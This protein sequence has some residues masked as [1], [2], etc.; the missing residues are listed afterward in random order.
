MRTAGLIVLAS[1]LFLVS[2]LLLVW[3][4]GFITGI[5]GSL[6][7]LLLVIALLI[8]PVGTVVGVALLVMASRQSPPR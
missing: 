1:T 3:F 8:A 5:A 6:V 2:L 4:S 7:H